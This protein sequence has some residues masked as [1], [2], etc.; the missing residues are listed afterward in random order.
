MIEHFPRDT[1]VVWAEVP[2]AAAYMVEWD[3][4]DNPGWA[5]ERT[6][7][8]GS[9]RTLVPVASFQFVDA[10]TGRW[11]VWAVDAAGS[12]GPKTEWREFRYTRQP[13]ITIGNPIDGHRHL[14]LLCESLEIKGM[15]R[16]SSSAITC[17]CISGRTS[18]S[19]FAA[20]ANRPAW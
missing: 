17:A 8:T 14:R 4:R 13:R 12:A 19:L 2:S 1:A 7:A 9:V 18:A 11:R 3:Y 6:G 20:C 5:S 15:R 16:G 10:Q